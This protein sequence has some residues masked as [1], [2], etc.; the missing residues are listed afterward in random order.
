MRA[1][2]FPIVERFVDC[3]ICRRIL[4]PLGKRPFPSSIILGL[5]RAKCRHDRARFGKFRLGKE[6]IVESKTWYV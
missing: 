4:Q 3:G 2:D 1:K 5:D 6:L